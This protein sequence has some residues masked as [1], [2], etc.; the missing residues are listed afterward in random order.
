MSKKSIKNIYADSTSESEIDALIKNTTHEIVT[1]K[2]MLNIGYPMKMVGKTLIDI[3]SG[4]SPKLSMATILAGCRKYIAVDRENVLDEIRKFY[5]LRQKEYS[6]NIKLISTKN[7]DG[8]LIHDLDCE[9][10]G[11]EDI[12]C[13]TQMFLMHIQEKDIRKDIIKAI[14][15]KG[16]TCLFTETD[17]SSFQYSDGVLKDFQNAFKNFFDFMGIIGNYGGSIHKEIIEVI[18]ENKLSIS[19]S[20]IPIHIS[21]K[22]AGMQCWEELV[23]LAERAI[24]ALSD[25]RPFLVYFLKGIQKRLI[26]EKPFAL[27]P[28]FMSVVTKAI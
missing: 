4:P 3:A 8:N 10:S 16:K 27:R 13:H 24:I 21:D 6:D 19:V 14:L 9:C 20:Q 11:F 7:I 12:I 2:L 5:N 18:R 26:E 15:L 23:Q 17:W 25:K 1:V 22:E 28:T